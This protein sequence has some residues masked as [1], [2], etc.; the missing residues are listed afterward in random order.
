MTIK[1][2][3]IATALALVSIPAAAEE[4][5][6]VDTTWRMVGSNDS[7]IIEAYDDPGVPGVTCHVSRAQTGGV[8]VS[9]DPSEASIACRQI[10]PVDWEA[11]T[12]LPQTEPAVFRENTSLLFKTLK[13]ARLV[14]A[15]RHTLVYLVYTT[16]GWDGSPKNVVSSV[17]IVSWQQQ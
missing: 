4:I 13:V 11:V 17:P 2:A 15:K 12:R 3:F 10:G 9:R 5:G 14:D 7:I 6:H 16:E 1:S 8:F